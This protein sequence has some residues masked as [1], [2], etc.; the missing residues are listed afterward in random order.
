VPAALARVFQ[1]IAERLTDAGGDGTG[2]MY[3]VLNGV[4]S[5]FT[6]ASEGL[7]DAHGAWHEAHGFWFTG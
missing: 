3:A 1:N 2:T 6:A 4:S 7:A 5:A